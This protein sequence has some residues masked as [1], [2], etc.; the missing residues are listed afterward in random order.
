MAE[1]QSIQADS[2]ALQA[3]VAGIPVIS[4]VK[5]TVVESFE[6]RRGNTGTDFLWIKSAYICMGK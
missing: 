3:W 5:I 2:A 1:A 6:S 4:G